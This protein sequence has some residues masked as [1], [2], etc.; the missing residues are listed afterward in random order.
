M[1]YDRKM[2][3]HLDIGGGG[4]GIALR[5]QHAC[6]THRSPRCSFSPSH[7]YHRCQIII[8]CLSLQF[9]A[10]L[11]HPHS[12]FDTKWLI[13]RSPLCRYR[14]HASFWRASKMTKFSPS[15]MHTKFP[16]IDPTRPLMC[17]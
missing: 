12:T 14:L 9:A 8:S 4:V 2:H 11:T 1:A 17:D 7:F 15:K 3:F 5:V 13:L 10:T 6:N 16:S